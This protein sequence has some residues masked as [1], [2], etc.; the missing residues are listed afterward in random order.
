MYVRARVTLLIDVCRM[1]WN[2]MER[3]GMGAL[4]LGLFI[5]G[6]YLGL[7]GSERVKIRIR[8]YRQLYARW[9]NVLILGRCFGSFLRDVLGL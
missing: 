4:S 7:L 6:G 2:G 8:G 9:G 5:K 3:N 1:E